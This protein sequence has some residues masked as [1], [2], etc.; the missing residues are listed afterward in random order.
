MK[1]LS[2]NENKIR[3]FRE[4]LWEG[5]EIEKGRDLKEVDWTAKEVIVYKSLEAWKG[6]IVED[7]IVKIGWKEMVDIRW[8]IEWLKEYIWDRIQCIV[9]LWYNTG[10]EIIIYKWVVNGKVST[11]LWRSWFWFDPFFIPE[12]EERSL[13][14]LAED[15]LKHKF[16]ARRIAL[17]KMACDD[18][19]DLV[20]ISTIWEWRWSYQK[21]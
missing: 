12:W 3:E 5:I 14:Q 13:A 2:S 6:Y 8:N 17:E 19:E 20:Q 16:S 15:G 21:H 11:P 4:I 18:K 10:S 7:T 1:L 9:H